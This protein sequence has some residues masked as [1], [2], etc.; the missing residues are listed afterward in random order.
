[1]EYLNVAVGDENGV[2]ETYVESQ[3][4][5]NG[6]GSRSDPVPG[7]QPVI[8][9]EDIPGMDLTVSRRAPASGLP[10]PARLFVSFTDVN[11]PNSGAGAV[12]PLTDYSNWV[13][14]DYLLFD[15]T[16]TNQPCGP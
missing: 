12:F 6:P 7:D 13:E 1:M 8:I 11:N 9:G 16:V 10:N 14:G 15:G 5:P 4:I 2:R 3:Y